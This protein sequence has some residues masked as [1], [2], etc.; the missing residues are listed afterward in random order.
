M[1]I[2]D[3]TTISSIRVN[4]TADATLALPFFTIL[5]ILV[6]S[7]VE[8]GAVERRV[9]VEHVLPAPACRVRFVLIRPLSPVVLLRHWIDRDA[10]QELQ[11]AAGR[12][13]LHRHAVHQLLEVGRITFAARLDLERA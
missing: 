10:P 1:T 3:I 4:P 5:P 6:F 8:G 9:D 11:L 13:V 12:V 7:S 2:S